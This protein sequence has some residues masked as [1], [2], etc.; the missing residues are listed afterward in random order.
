[1][2][3]CHNK[4]RILHAINYLYYTIRNTNVRTG[5]GAVGFSCEFSIFRA[6]MNPVYRPYWNVAGIWASHPD[7]E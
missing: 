7:K 4:R 6:D 1:M 3:S 5:F 2:N